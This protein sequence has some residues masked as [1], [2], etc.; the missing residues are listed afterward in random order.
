VPYDAGLDMRQMESG[1]DLRLFASL[2]G[3]VDGFAT[4]F[5]GQLCV[6]SGL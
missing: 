1:S 6:K 5:P 2:V 3:N 4:I